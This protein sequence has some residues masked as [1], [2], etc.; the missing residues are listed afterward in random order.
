MVRE[1]D[2][3]DARELKRFVRL[4]R[5]L[6]G[7]EPLYWSDTD[8]DVGK[9]LAGRSALA[10]GMELRLFVS[11]GIG[12]CAAIVNHRWQAE[13]EPDTAFIGY[14]A[15]A[16]DAEEE[17]VEMLAAAEEWLAGRGA[18]RV[19]AP[20]NGSGMLGMGVLTNAHDESPMFPL[21][22][23]PPYYARYVEAAGY[24][25]AYPLYV[26]EVDLRSPQYERTSR[27]GIEEAQC[28]VRHIDKRRWSDDLD[29][30][31]RIFNAGFRDEWEMHEYD[32]AE[33]DALYGSL[34]PVLDS[35]FVLFGELDGE[36][37]GICAGLPDWTPLFRSFRGKFGALQLLRFLRGGK[38]IERAGLVTIALAPGHRG[39]RVG[40]TL[41]AHL[42]RTFEEMGLDRSPYY[43]V[44]E[45]NTA[46]RG[47]AKSFGGQERL[48]YHCYD[49]RLD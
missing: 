40:R 6:L 17:I 16:P 48:L 45:V 32:R 37:V 27:S 9:R 30:Y 3:S 29:L 33:F 23:N 22:W 26:Y 24:S 49:K 43:L 7:S 42:F 38:R 25:K 47:L 12:R 10:R 11:D 5:E 20:V 21:P 13:R 18:T 35:R 41:A 39:K 4:E 44:N 28:S 1:I 2:P 34:K 14:L 31:R 8:A 36:T 15:A 19:I 46:S